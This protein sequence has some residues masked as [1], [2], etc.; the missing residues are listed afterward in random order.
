MRHSKKCSLP[1]ESCP[2]SCSHPPWSCPPPT[3]ECALGGCASKGR[4]STALHPGRLSST[5]P[6]HP[7]LGNLLILDPNSA[8]K[9]FHKHMEWPPGEAAGSLARPVQPAPDPRSP[10]SSRSFMWFL[11]RCL[12][13]SKCF[14]HGVA[15]SS[16]R[17]LLPAAHG[18]REEKSV[19]VS[20]R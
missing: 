13:Q 6:V 15:R 10:G 12:Q 19:E 14:F 18:S 1:Q 11:G 2:D 8:S 20:A 4:S 3:Q 9:S 16:G 5:P 7:V 17:R